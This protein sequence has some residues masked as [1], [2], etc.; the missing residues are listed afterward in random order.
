MTKRIVIIGAAGRDFHN[1][2]TVYRN[3]PNYK[4][5]AF[6][7]AQI[8]D[9][10]G[11]RYPADLAGYLILFAPHAFAPQRQLSARKS[12]SPPVFLLISVHFTAPLGIPLSPLIL[13]PQS[14]R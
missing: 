7:A 10:A 12:P 5:V 3:D 1:F 4:V 11:R 14:F 2:N 13:K 8:P 6:T 9:I